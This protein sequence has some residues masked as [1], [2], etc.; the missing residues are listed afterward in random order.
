MP[1][2]KL[3]SATTENVLH[4]VTAA[5]MLADRKFNIT[6]LNHAAQ[7]LF[8]QLEAPL[9]KRFPAFRADR[10]VGMNMDIFHVNPEH[11]RALLKHLD[12]LPHTARIRVEGAV[13]SL[14]VV[15]MYNEDGQ[16]AG[17]LL[18]WGDD[19]ARSLYEEELQALHEAA[20]AGDLSY[21][22]DVS[23]M[24]ADFARILELVNSVFGGMSDVVH[25][26]GDAL[27]RSA[28]GDLSQ[29]IS[30]SF[31]GDH[32]SLRD[33]Y[34]TMI[35]SL[36]DTLRQVQLAVDRIASGSS[37]VTSTAQDLANGAST[38]AEAIV[39]IGATVESVAEQAQHTAT[40]AR[41]SGAAS[42]RATL[43]A[44]QG[45]ACMDAM[46]TSMTKIDDASNQIARII[47]VIDEIAFQT[48]LLA[49]NA[50]VE[51][52]R[53]GAHGRG[54]A[55]VAEEVRNLAARSANAAKETTSII[56]TTLKRVA[57]GSAA[58]RETA[59]ALQGIVAAVEESRSVASEISEA[60][61]A[62]ANS[63]ADVHNALQQIDRVTQTNSA[64]AQQSAAAAEE[65]AGQA[66][67]LE[68]LLTGF[69]LTAPKRPAF[70]HADLSTGAAGD[71]SP[72][73]WSLF[74]TFL[75]SQDAIQAR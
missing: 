69:Q 45:E 42:E 37:Q 22:G 16:H 6:F 14:K 28:N 57:D 10:L 33:D 49:L 19:T 13:I 23:R 51:A 30:A 50:A 74:E 24:E 59:E 29:P 8:E 58:A 46:L 1:P 60:A 47:K 62:Q 52:A 34:N 7:E 55:V 39:Q 48:N 12:R 53:A 3:P 41:R 66:G 44:E 35:H 25:T 21:R 67:A 9:R 36:S 61:E 26:T 63:V 4:G 17:F 65:L 18:E 72:E 27:R 68:T 43:S 75:A 54:F 11:Q 40:A 64:A 71:I 15:G 2:S 5:V 73:L 20:D 70:A 56:E 31:A 38:Q 32:A